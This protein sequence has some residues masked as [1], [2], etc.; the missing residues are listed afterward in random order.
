[1]VPMLFLYIKK[2]VRMDGYLTIKEVS[3]KW[4]VSP[5]QVQKMCAEGK[6]TGVSKFGKSWVIPETVKRPKDGRITTGEYINWRTK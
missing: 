4:G 6:I 3:E 5:R 2:G 1:M